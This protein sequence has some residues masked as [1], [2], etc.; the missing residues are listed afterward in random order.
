MKCH[1]MNASTRNARADTIVITRG[2]MTLAAGAALSFK[3][4]ITTDYQVNVPDIGLS[5]TN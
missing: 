4:Q 2:R 3:A 1:A 5:G